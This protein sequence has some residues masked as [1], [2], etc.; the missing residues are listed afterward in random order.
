MSIDLS[1]LSDPEVLAQLVA[2]LSA[3]KPEPHKNPDVVLVG[4]VVLSVS[5]LEDALKVLKRG[6]WKSIRPALKSIDSPLLE[7][8][9]QTIAEKQKVALSAIRE[10]DVTSREAFINY[11]EEVAKKNDVKFGPSKLAEGGVV[12]SPPEFLISNDC[13]TNPVTLSAEQARK[14]G[15]MVALKLSQ[16][17]ANRLAVETGESVEDLHLTLKF[18]GSDVTE[19]SEEDRQTII[20]QVKSAVLGIGPITGRVFSVSYF[21]PDSDN[22]ALVLGVG[23]NELADLHKS[24]EFVQTPE[25]EHKPWVPHITIK[26]TNDLTLAPELFLKTTQPVTF[27]RVEVVFEGDSVFI[28][29]VS[30]D[31][32]LEDIDMESVSDD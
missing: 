31:N 30:D 9:Y 12:N 3:P 27:D 26:Y 19:L 29:L 20:E 32:S 14:T 7:I 6:K 8:D 21:N 10:D 1:A 23:G 11:L 25:D 2:R 24:L 22:P 13:V 18:L 4:K 28:P 17:D 5:A 15:G 16:E